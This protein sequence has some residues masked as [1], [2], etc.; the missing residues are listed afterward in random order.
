MIN[1]MMIVAV[2]RG[3]EELPDDPSSLLQE[4]CTIMAPTRICQLMS[5]DFEHTKNNQEKDEV[6]LKYLRLL[7]PSRSVSNHLTSSDSFYSSLFLPQIFWY[8][9]M[10]DQILQIAL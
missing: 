3:S 8:K 7:F 9:K 2:T 6:M 1:I 4:C 10:A 5:L